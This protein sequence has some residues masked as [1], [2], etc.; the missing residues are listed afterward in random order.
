[1]VIMTAIALLTSPAHAASTAGGDRLAEVGVVV[2]LGPGALPPPDTEAA[3]YVVADL[4]TGAVLAAKSAHARLPPAS[5]LKVLTS[6]VLLPALDK[7]QIVTGTDEDMA[8]EGSKVGIAAGLSYSVD[9]LF[10]AML[11]D[12][13]NDA[14]RALARVGGGVEQTV[15][16]MN[17]LAVQLHALDTVAVNP[18]GLDEPAQLTSAYDLALIA[19]AALQREDFRN[20][21]TTPTADLPAQD[22]TTYQIQNGNRL[23]GAYDGMIGGKNGYTTLARHT[24]VG[25]AERGDHAYLVSVMRTEA[26]AEVS[27]AALLDWAFVNGGAVKPVGTLADPSEVPVVS[28]SP[29]GSDEPDATMGAPAV[30]GEDSPEATAPE[31]GAGGGLGALGTV[32][33]VG[34]GLV[35]AVGA[36]RVRAVR[37]ERMRRELMGRRSHADSRRA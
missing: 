36:L 31:A 13:G 27:A 35:G 12:S 30:A 9:L 4:G 7:A 34:V 19:R 6:L 32:G 2:E 26:R 5:T 23:L 10:K 14:T 25:A 21:L 20:Y 28:A 8:V 3:S 1:M 37:R 33:L 24:Y 15:S 29:A 16:A 22:G 11:L 17:A 18:D